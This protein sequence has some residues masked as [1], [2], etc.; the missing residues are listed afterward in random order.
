[1]EW[2]K[3][4]FSI[5]VSSIKLDMHMQNKETILCYT[6]KLL[7]MY[8][9]GYKISSCR[10]PERKCRS[11]SLTLVLAIFFFFLVCFTP[12][13]KTADANNK[14]VECIKQKKKSQQM[15]SPTKPFETKWMN[16]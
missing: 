13:T 16:L 15:K 9:L 3:I 4:V 11:N 10:N 14:Q 6:Q 8:L 7:R 2:K 1:M 12:K 5:N